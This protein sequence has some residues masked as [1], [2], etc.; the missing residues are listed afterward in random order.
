MGVAHNNTIMLLGRFIT[1]L[2][3]GSVRPVGMVYVGE[4]SDPKHRPITLLCPSIAVFVGVLLSHTVGHYLPWRIACF[5]S[6][7]PNIVC[8]ITLMFLKESPLWLINNGKIEEGIEA[9]KEFRG[10]GETAIRE[11]KSIL[12][13]QEQKNTTSSFKEFTNVIFSKPFIKSILIILLLFLAVQMCGINTI[14]FYAQDIFGSTFSG[15]VD[16]FMLMIIT[17]VIRLITVSSICLFINKV[18]RRITFL[19][20]C[21]G[22]VLV[23][24]CLVIYLYLK[25]VG[26]LWVAL[27]CMVVYL[28][29]AGSMSCISWS[30]VAEIFPSNVRGLG[31]GISSFISFALLFFSVKVTPG[32]LYNF[33]DAVLYGGFAMITLISAV[34]LT[35]LLPETNGKSLQDLENSLYNKKSKDM[36]QCQT[37]L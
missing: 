18:P 22:T 14:S 1:G 23:L 11:L 36:E 33:G 2:C 21:Y 9:F 28:G 30:F 34:S 10:E 8:F 5:V 15:E 13:N 4:I 24:S 25:P 3:T 17:D 32:V 26:L 7:L 16:A 20:S 37:T 35:F 19:V 31:S 29:I 12:E 6:A 27:S